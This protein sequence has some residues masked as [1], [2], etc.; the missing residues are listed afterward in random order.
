MG[1]LKTVWFC[2]SF[3]FYWAFLFALAALWM[4]QTCP[5]YWSVEHFERP[6]FL[7]V[8]ELPRC[9]A[10]AA[11]VH[12]GYRWFS[13]DHEHNRDIFSQQQS[14]LGPARGAWKW[15]TPCAH[16]C[17]EPC[18][19]V[20]ATHA[21]LCGKVT[22]PAGSTLNS[23]W[24]FMFCLAARI[25]LVLIFSWPESRSTVAFQLLRLLRFWMVVLS[26]AS[27]RCTRSIAEA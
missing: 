13:V 19:L 6:N 18:G 10:C 21:A 1:Y 8:A 20:C 11:K 16:V 15:C 14:F 3:T 5:S 7:N 26:S 12:K 24:L 23:K 4:H 9:W 2:G 17:T 22:D 25:W 27:K